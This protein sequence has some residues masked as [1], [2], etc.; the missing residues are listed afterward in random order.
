MHSSNTHVTGKGYR[1]VKIYKIWMKWMFI[2]Q[3][4]KIHF[5][6]SVDILSHIY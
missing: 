4:N 1:E 6:E 2:K 3:I 5:V